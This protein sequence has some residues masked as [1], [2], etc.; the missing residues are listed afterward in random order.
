MDGGAMFGVVPKIL[1]GKLCPA[2]ENNF[3]NWAMRCLLIDD[4]E[5]RILIDTGIG[6]KQDEKFFSKFHL[7]GKDNLTNSLAINGYEANDITD[8]IFTHLHFDH[9]GGA[10]ILNKDNGHTELIFKNATHWVSSQQWN[11]ALNPNRKE[12][13]S[14]LKENI[15]P[16]ETSGHLSFIEKDTFLTPDIFLKLVYGHTAGQIIPFIKYKDKTIVFMG[17]MIA[18][19]A[20]IP[21]PYVMGYDVHPLTVIEEK[22]FFL[23]EAAEKQYILFFEHDLNVECCTVYK[24]EKNDFCVR[25]AFNLN[26]II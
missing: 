13:A 21:I 9:A 24:T 15:L 22:E 4:G 18:S 1:W 7:N 10:L 25:S 12:K 3:C 17:D 5:K 20:H 11:C 26:D 14:F 16:L 19:S 6:D 8:V 23:A 2:D